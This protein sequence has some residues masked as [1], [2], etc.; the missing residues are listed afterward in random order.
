VRE[1]IRR[2]EQGDG[3]ELRHDQADYRGT[4]E[5]RL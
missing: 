3:R 2:A 1:G 4:V 5:V